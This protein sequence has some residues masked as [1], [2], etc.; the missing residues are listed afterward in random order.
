M[1]SERSDEIRFFGIMSRGY[2]QLAKAVMLD[3]DL[4]IEAKAI[5]AYFVSF[6][7]AGTHSA[8]PSRDKIIHDLHI[9]KDTYYKHFKLLL[10]YGYITVE[11]QNESRFS[12]NIY[13][14]VL[15]PEKY[16][17][18]E[19]NASEARRNALYLIRSA[20][21]ISAAGYGNVPKS[22]MTDSTISIQAKSIY[23]YFCVW[24]GQD[25]NAT[26][27]RD[28]ILFHLGITHSTYNKHMNQ[29]I[30][31]NYIT[32][33][34]V[35]VSGRFAGYVF[36]INTAVEKSDSS[37]EAKFS[38]T[39]KPDAEISD[40]VIQD[41]K[42]SDAIKPDTVKSDAEIS[43]TNNTNISIPIKNNTILYHNQSIKSLASRARSVGW[44][45]NNLLYE[46][47][48]N[49][50]LTSDIL[51]DKE[52]LS[53]AVRLISGADC[54]FKGSGDMN[55][56]DLK[57]LQDFFNLCLTEML[58]P[59]GTGTVVSGVRISASQVN[60]VLTSLLEAGFS[61]DGAYATVSQLPSSVIEE[62]LQRSAQTQIKNHK[63]YMKSIIWTTMNSLKVA[64]I[65]SMAYDFGP[66]GAM[67]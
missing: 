57:T 17:Q 49:E 15:F 1:V 59:G 11:Q 62:F 50:S 6:T 40:T 67:E 14:I 61:Q 63:A 25:M 30:E 64:G 65:S 27:N 43:D 41:T 18:D 46:I 32:R 39:V 5:Y 16:N 45:I 36:H 66:N 29:L 4:T 47:A 24:A 8:F 26:P 51:N 12:K 48:E 22:V 28:T 55:P 37:P 58:D 34:S 52:K 7:G 23:A 3:P 44:D 9:S 54:M 35:S 33:S 60:S 19:S 2:G 56:E 31:H 38:D 10:D 21:D 13:T 53:A 20:H 42:I